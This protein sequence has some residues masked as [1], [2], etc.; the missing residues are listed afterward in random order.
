MAESYLCLHAEFI[1]C[2][3]EAK[4]FSDFLENP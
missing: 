4:V 2:I 3:A 1:G